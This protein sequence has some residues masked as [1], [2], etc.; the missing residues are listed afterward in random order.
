MERLEQYPFKVDVLLKYGTDLTSLARMGK[1]DP[2][3]GRQVEVDRVTQTLCKRRKNNACLI[4]DPGVGK[5]VVVEGLAA[6]IAYGSC[7]HKMMGKKVFAIDM[8]RL[9]SGASNRGEFEERLIKLVDEVVRSE[10]LVIL[11]IDEL[12]TLIGAGTGSGAQALDAA[13]ILK[14]ALAR[15]DLKCIGATTLDEYKKY[16]EKD[17][18]LKRRFQSIDVPEPS[19]EEALEILRGV[20]NKYETFHGVSYTDAALNAAVDLSKQYVSDRYLP[21]KAV[22]LIDEAG[23]RVQL[24][25]TGP[26]SSAVI[27]PVTEDDI[28]QVISMWTGIPLEKLSTEESNRLLGLEKVFRRRLI[29]Q[30]EAVSSVCRAIRRTRVGLRDTNQ[31]IASFLFTG[32]TGV[33]KTELARI[34]AEEYF[35]SEEAM[36]RLDMSEYMESHSVSRLFGSPPGYVG[37]EDGGQLTEAV[38]RRPHTVILFDEIEKANPRVLNALLQVLDDGRLTDGKGRCVDFKNTIIIFTSNIGGELKGDKDGVK[39]EVGLLLKG[40]FKPEL[41]NRMDEIVVFKSLKKIHLSEILEA[42]LVKFY[43]RAEKTRI[44]VE[45]GN[46]LKEKLISEGYSSSYGA[47]PLRRAITRLL[48]DNLA[49]RILNGSVQ[50]R[51]KM[52]IV[53][54]AD[55]EMLIFS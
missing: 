39:R 7:P 12:H 1:L 29:G 21:D 44:N 27:S 51:V 43:K 37:H 47:R 26:H 19:P 41:L 14:P 3:I 5:T 24:R 6:K 49:E 48:E 52:D 10:G 31:P 22:D 55:G 34:L 25:K 42:M 4:G 2:M 17:P 33:G 46:A 23:A 18:A 35:G 53:D 11:F 13:N 54:S 30:D 15:G 9:I 28:Q 32:P 45:V 20:Q 50:N 36:V 38:R 40:F 8:A 16:I